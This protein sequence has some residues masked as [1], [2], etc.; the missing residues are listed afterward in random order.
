MRGRLPFPVLQHRLA[1]LI[2]AGAG[3]T[4]RDCCSMLGTGAHPRG[5]GADAAVAFPMDAAPGSSPR[6][7]GR[8]RLLARHTAGRRL[9]PAGAGQTRRMALCFASTWAHPRG[10][11][12]DVLAATSSATLRGS[13][14]RVRG[15]R[16]LPCGCWASGGLIPAGA[17][18]TRRS[19]KGPSGCTAHPRGC[20]A[21]ERACEIDLPSDGSSPRVRGRPCAQGFR[22]H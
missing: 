19:P 21:D 4:T 16:Y 13:S 22:G 5:C 10:C 14:P 11:G 17:G 6:V 18:Q 20:G 8:H 2:P 15:R 12:A 9:I 1:G 7:R 3:Q